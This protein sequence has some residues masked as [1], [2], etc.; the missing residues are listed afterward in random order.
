MIIYIALFFVAFVLIEFV[1]LFN[2]IIKQHNAIVD[3]QQEVRDNKFKLEVFEVA[4][5][6]LGAIIVWNE[7][8]KE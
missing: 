2:E 8:E 5:D 3:L 1:V 4:L 6:G 7:K